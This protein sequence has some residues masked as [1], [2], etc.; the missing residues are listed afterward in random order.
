MAK[1]EPQGL[2]FADLRERFIGW[3]DSARWSFTATSVRPGLFS[4][5]VER[6]RIEPA[7]EQSCL[8]VYRAAFDFT[9]AGRLIDRPIMAFVNRAIGPTLQR[10]S[11]A[12]VKRHRHHRP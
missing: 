5:F 4:R 9:R 6:I 11:D 10:M 3:E 8:I 2:E 1:T 12:A 7:D